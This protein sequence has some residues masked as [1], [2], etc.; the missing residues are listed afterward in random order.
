MKEFNHWKVLNMYYLLQGRG[1]LSVAI[2]TDLI[3]KLL[4]LASTVGLF[5]ICR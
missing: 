3:L 1:V 4:H 5:A 2:Q